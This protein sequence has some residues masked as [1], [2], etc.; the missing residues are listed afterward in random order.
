MA[1][2]LVLV[3]LVTGVMLK[4][5]YA[6]FP[7]RAYD[8]LFE[9]QRSASL[10][11][12]IRNVHHWAANVLILAVFLHMLR[13][14]YT[15]A[16]KE[17]RRINWVIGLTL[18]SSI[19]ISNFTGY[20]MPWDQLAY[21]AVTI[22]AAMLA[23]IPLVGQWLQAT[24]IGGPELGPATLANFYAIHTTII[25]AL[26]IILMPFHFWRIRKAGGLAATGGSKVEV[27][28]HLFVR[29]LAMAA[30]VIALV[31]LLA[32]FVDAPLGARANPGLS[33]NPTK[34]PWY[35]AG[36]QEM[37][38]HLPPLMAVALIPALVGGLLVF[39]PFAPFRIQRPGMWFGTSN[40]KRMAVAAAVIGAIFAPI[41]ILGHNQ[42]LGFLSWL[43]PLAVV[44][45]LVGLLIVTKHHFGASDREAVQ[46]AFT[47]LLVLF[48][49]LTANGIW[50]RGAS[51][52]L[53]WPW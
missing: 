9:L 41:W 11:Q 29:E 23:Y 19:L 17:K 13:V 37:L 5:V 6:P 36:L 16:F 21:W 26:L 30:A 50:F 39:L 18:F 38:L 42:G 33:P 28:P 40:G 27:I 46:S 4:F 14:F 32:A 8:S 1:A 34:A 22:C 20:L 35:F 24:I 25:P 45:I 10:G 52:T 44:M 2:T 47:F 49:M 31:M 53:T 3:M 48:I 15:G 51:M 7:D 12:F 43:A